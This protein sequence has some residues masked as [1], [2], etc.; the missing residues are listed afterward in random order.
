M[1]ALALGDVHRD[2]PDA[3]RRHYET[4]IHL[5]RLSGLPEGLEV[6]RAAE[7]RLREPAD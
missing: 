3:R 1:A 6:A 7:L 2:E 4:A 5:G